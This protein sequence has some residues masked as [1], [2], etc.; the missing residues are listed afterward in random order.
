MNGIKFE[1]RS[2]SRYG[3]ER[4]QGLNMGSGVESTS[5]SIENT[6]NP[7]CLNCVN[8]RGKLS[9]GQPSDSRRRGV[10]RYKYS[11]SGGLSYLLPR[12]FSK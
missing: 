3:A 1:M 4:K 7:R 2:E 9:V 8:S 6:Y 11:R 12:A 5:K 10:L